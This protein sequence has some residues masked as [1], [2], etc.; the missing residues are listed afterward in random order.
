MNIIEK[1]KH[2]KRKQRWNRQYKKG[3]WENLKSDKESGRYKTIVEYSE[4]YGNKN[5]NILDLG[6]GEGVLLDYFNSDLI[7]SFDGMDFSSVSIKKAN[8]ANRA[9][10][11]FT[12]EDL[13]DFKPKTNYDIIVLNEAFYYIHETKK[14]EVIDTLKAHLKTNGIIIVSIYREGLGCWE[15]FKNHDFEELDFTTV[16]THEEKTYWKIGVY[17]LT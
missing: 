15:Y 14:Q 7:S 9:K 8:K 6:S 12:C 5:P 2:W 11:T 4:R 3:R 17:K 16:T 1:F 10:G 13:H